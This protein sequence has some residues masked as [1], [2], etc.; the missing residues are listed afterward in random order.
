MSL[1]GD[2]G[3]AVWAPAKGGQPAQLLGLLV[4][5]DTC[6]WETGVPLFVD[7][8]DPT[9]RSFLVSKGVPV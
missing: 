5:S 1:Q 2:T 6:H 7:L 9:V 4:Q 3:S 8:V